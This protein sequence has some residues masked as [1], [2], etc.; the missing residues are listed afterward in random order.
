MANGVFAALGLV[1]LGTLA[2]V[3]RIVGAGEK[4]S[5][6]EVGEV[7]TEAEVIVEVA[8]VERKVE[9]NGLV[10][11]PVTVEDFGEAIGRVEAVDE[12]DF[13]DIL[14]EEIDKEMVEAAV[15]VGVLE[16]EKMVVVEKEEEG[17]SQEATTSE[18]L[19][20]IDNLREDAVKAVKAGGDSTKG[21]QSTGEGR[22]KDKKSAKKK[23]KV[24]K[25]V[26]LSPPRLPSP[27]PM[28]EEL[29]KRK[30]KRKPDD[31]EGAKKRKKRKKMDEI[32]DLFAGLV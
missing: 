9:R 22:K 18:T 10:V 30:D 15:L 20:T 23:K 19:L 17:S 25:P 11:G 26:S 31:K 6:A 1:L 32:D 21:E 27:P 4:G 3:H 7:V 24:T 8:R 13:D 12:G 29:P 2:R 28:K 16:E 14:G 5:K